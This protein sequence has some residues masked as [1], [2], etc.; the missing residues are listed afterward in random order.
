MRESARLFM[1]HGYERTTMRNIAKAAGIKLGSIAYHFKSK[2][3]ILY[4]TM[5]AVIESAEDRA[6]ATL[7]TADDPRSK[8]QSLIEVELD[9]YL[10]DTVPA[11]KAP[12]RTH[13]TPAGLRNH[14][15]RRADGMPCEGH[16]PIEARNCPACP[17]GRVRVV[18]V[19]E[20]GGG[21]IRHRGT[22]R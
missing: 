19:V 3:D 15:V 6:L 10:N 16:H 11:E 9:S 14:L 13:Q 4:A 7:K 8:L 5:S 20:R 22:R 12:K 21:R 1:K 17:A 2:E 18:G